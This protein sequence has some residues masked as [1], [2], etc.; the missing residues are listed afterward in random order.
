MYGPVERLDRIVLQRLHDRL[1]HVPLTESVELAAVGNRIPVLHYRQGAL[2][3]REVGFRH[4]AGFHHRPTGCDDVAHDVPSKRIAAFLAL[5]RCVSNVGKLTELRQRLKR[6]A[7]FFRK[8]KRVE[9]A[10]ERTHGPKLTCHLRTSFIY[11]AF[12]RVAV[13]STR[14]GVA[15]TLRQWEPF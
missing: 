9:I 8:V 12:R 7:E 3:D 4:G 5:L 14:V 13:L 11:P 10:A 15:R 2:L 1:L 6:L